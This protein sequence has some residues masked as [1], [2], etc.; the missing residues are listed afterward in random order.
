MKDY[1]KKEDYDFRPARYFIPTD[2]RQL[3]IQNVK[4]NKRKTILLEMF[5]HGEIDDAFES[6]AESCLSESAR[7]LFGSIHP[8]FMGGEYLPNLIKDECEIARISMQSTTGDV[9]S[10]R[11]RLQSG[12][13]YHRIVDEYK[14]RYRVAIRTSEEPL[15]LGELVTQIDE[16][17]HEN[18]YKGLAIGIFEYQ[19]NECGTEIDDL[20]ADFLTV[21]SAYYPKLD[22]HYKKAIA[23]WFRQNQKCI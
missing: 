7:T 21:D 18:A 5:D 16:S 17:C 1:L 2:L 13:F 4:G 20:D 23:D 8:A 19:L 22:N 15:S 3:I 11:A 12:K 14:T 10:I 6:L 9:I